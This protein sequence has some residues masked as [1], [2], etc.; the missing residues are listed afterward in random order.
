MLW[1]CQKWWPLPRYHF[2]TLLYSS[3]IYEST[4]YLSIIFCSARFCS[5]PFCCFYSKTIGTECIYNFGQKCIARKS[6]KQSLKIRPP[7]PLKRETQSRV[8]LLIFRIVKTIGLVNQCFLGF[9]TSGTLSS[10]LEKNSRPCIE[11]HSILYRLASLRCH[12]NWKGSISLNNFRYT[13]IIACLILVN[14]TFSI[15]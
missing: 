8:F 2:P 13:H 11:G 1:L 7:S 12:W 10:G 15:K 3:C 5:L 9:Q 6:D 4:M 14:K